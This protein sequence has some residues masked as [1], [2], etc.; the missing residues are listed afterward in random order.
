[1]N[2]PSEP[3]WSGK[4]REEHAAWSKD[5]VVSISESQPR[6]SLQARLL[7]F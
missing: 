4:I 2:E 6:T 1:M 5:R 7:F 3:R